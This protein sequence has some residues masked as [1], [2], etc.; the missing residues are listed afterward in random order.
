MDDPS[1]PFRTLEKALNDDKRIRYHRNYLSNLTAAIR[2]D[3]CNVRG[4]FVWSFLDNWEWNMGYTVRFGLYYVDFRNKLTRIPKDS[5]QWFKNM[6]RIKTE[7]NEISIAL[8]YIKFIFSLKI[9][10]GNDIYKGGKNDDE[11]N[12]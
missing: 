5:V 8:S 10:E 6:L 1:G 3:D 11:A 4:Y 9:N 7:H 12:N 2:E